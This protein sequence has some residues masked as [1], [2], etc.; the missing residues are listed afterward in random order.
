LISDR[1]CE[2]QFQTFSV[3]HSTDIAPNHSLHLE[4]GPI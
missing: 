1:P 3:G 4:I 2:C